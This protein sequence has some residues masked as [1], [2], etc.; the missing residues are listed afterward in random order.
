MKKII[1]IILLVISLVSCNSTKLEKETVSKKVYLADTGLLKIK[2]ERIASGILLESDNEKYEYTLYEN[3]NSRSRVSYNI[4][5]EGSDKNAYSLLKDMIGKNIKV[6]YE[7]IHDESI[8]D[9]EII[10]SS[11]TIIN[12]D[13]YR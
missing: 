1:F 7:L 8:W 4:R 11:I 12:E 6:S 3:Y 2:E 5:K 10:I 9:K 13:I